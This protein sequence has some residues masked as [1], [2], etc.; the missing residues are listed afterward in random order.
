MTRPPTTR[1]TG[2]LYTEV[3]IEPLPGLVL[4]R[5]QYRA[6]GRQC[7]QIAPHEGRHGLKAERILRRAAAP[8]PDEEG[9]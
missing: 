1:Y 4:P 6:M 7:C 8:V 2:D 3:T 5:C 9:A